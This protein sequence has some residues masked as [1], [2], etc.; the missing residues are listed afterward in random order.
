MA[1]LTQFNDVHLE[2]R[3]RDYL[4]VLLGN[5]Y[6]LC[7]VLHASNGLEDLSTDSNQRLSAI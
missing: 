2:D 6:E 1:T 4:A 5:A 3:L 7:H